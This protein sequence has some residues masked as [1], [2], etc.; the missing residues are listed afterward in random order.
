[1]KLN[2]EQCLSLLPEPPP[3]TAEELD[4]ITNPRFD[5]IYC[6]KCQEEVTKDG[7]NWIACHCYGCRDTDSYPQQWESRPTQRP[8]DG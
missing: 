6:T 5:I 2:E 4:I 1:M 3:Y 8:A 7:K